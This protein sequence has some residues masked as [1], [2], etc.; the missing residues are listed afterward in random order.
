[1]NM[2]DPLVRTLAEDCVRA[3]LAGRDR[4]RRVASH[5]VWLDG[6][7][8]EWLTLQGRDGGIKIVEHAPRLAV[9]GRLSAEAVQRLIRPAGHGFSPASIRGHFRRETRR[10]A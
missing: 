7:E 4:P 2:T 8:R 3:A 1:M 9:I 10:Q 5:R 6:R